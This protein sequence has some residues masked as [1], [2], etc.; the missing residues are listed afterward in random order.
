MEFGIEKRPML[1]MKSVK[2]QIT[3]EIEL[4]NKKNSKCLEKKETT[5]FFCGGG[6]TGS[7]LHKT[8]DERKNEKRVL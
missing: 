6:V 3:E 8:R 1:K 5:I 2:R 4:L 7:K